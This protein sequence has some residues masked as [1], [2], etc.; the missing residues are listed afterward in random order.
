MDSD[1]RSPTAG[2]WIRGAYWLNRAV[3]GVVGIYVVVCHSVWQPI[4]LGLRREGSLDFDDCWLATMHLAW[5][6]RWQFS[7]DLVF[8]AGPYSFIWGRMYHPETYHWVV[9]G[10]LI[11]GLLLVG[12][13][14]LLFRLYGLSLAV[15]A[16][17][18]LLLFEL[19]HTSSDA[20]GYSMTFLF[21]L[22]YFFSV[23]RE[24][25]TSWV[26]MQALATAGL[27]LLALMKHSL[28]VASS[29]AIVLVSLDT[30]FRRR[31]IPVELVVFSFAFLALWLLA[32][33]PFSSLP[34][35]MANLFEVSGGYSEAM[36]RSAGAPSRLVASLVLSCLAL[37]A[38]AIATRILGHWGRIQ[39]ITAS[40]AYFWLIHKATFVREGGRS[41]IAAIFATVVLIVAAILIMRANAS[42]PLVNAALAF[43]VVIALTLVPIVSN[44]VLP[45]FVKRFLAVR[46]RAQ[47]SVKGFFSPELMRRRYSQELARVR[48]EFPLPSM[49]QGIADQYPHYQGVLIANGWP[50]RPRPVF[51]SY[52]AYTSRLAQL[53]RNHLLGERAPDRILFTVDPIDG[54]CPTIEDGL[55]WPVI[56][57]GY[58]I[59]F[60]PFPLWFVLRPRHQPRQRDRE[61]VAE[62]E[63]SIGQPLK[64]PD[65]APG[66]LLWAEIQLHRTIPGNLLSLAHKPP[67]VWVGVSFEEQGA[68]R[69]VAWSRLVPAVAASGFILSP[70]IMAR[71][72]F[73]EMMSGSRSWW[74]RHTVRHMTLRMRPALGQNWAYDEVAGYRFFTL[75]PQG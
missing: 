36:A 26:V 29:L 71:D 10:H 63:V 21:V 4:F 57:D 49:S 67:E 6:E 16:T 33:Q 28:L 70:M 9:A 25:G 73:R 60:E 66:T 30:I 51:H 39:A 35:Y 50:Y 32:A 2:A 3:P 65:L 27:A 69:P 24:R 37:T 74:V 17:V 7:T 14:G 13:T 48:V 55:S 68:R 56:L 22:S 31:R 12:V 20:V 58:E 15:S 52:S 19:V 44:A 38:L 8:T 46:Q 42:R 34:L 23:D 43:S 75:T 53:N 62:G 64:I 11:L 41:S 47:A 1:S 61:L 18:A 59:E 40:A 72:D 45:G 5:L 54:R